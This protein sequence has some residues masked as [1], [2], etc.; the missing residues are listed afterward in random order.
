MIEEELW[1]QYI[2]LGIKIID[3]AVRDLGCNQNN[4]SCDTQGTFCPECQYTAGEFMK[5]EH[6]LFIGL[7]EA[8]GIECSLSDII[9][10]RQR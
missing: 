7:M 6:S 5:G 8:V 1:V 2:E 3:Q 4:K 10:R 9:E